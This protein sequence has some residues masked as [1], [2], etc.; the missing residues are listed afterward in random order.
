MRLWPH[1]QRGL[2]H[3]EHA[4]VLGAREERVH[5]FQRFVV[6]GRGRVGDLD[7][8]NASITAAIAPVPPLKART[9]E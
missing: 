3:S 4:G 1:V 8:S 7:E 6:D 9:R 5:A 2:Q